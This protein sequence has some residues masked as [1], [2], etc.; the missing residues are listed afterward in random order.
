MSDV[1]I[2]ESPID[3]AFV[4]LNGIYPSSDDDLDL[5]GGFSL[6]K[7]N[8]FLL[9]A[10]S[11]YFMGKGEFKDAA[12]AHRYLIYR[13]S[14]S[15]SGQRPTRGAIVANLQNGLLAFQ[16]I[17]PVQ[18]LG[19]IFS[20]TDHGTPQFNLERIE[21]R[22]PTDAGEWAWMRHFEDGLLSYVPDMIRR[23]L[24][25]MADQ[26][27][28]RKNALSFLQ[29]GLE[30]RHPLIAGL[31]WVTGLEALLNSNGRYD[32][33]KKVS[34]CL[35]AD[36]F[37][38]PD[39]NS[40]VFSPPNTTVSDIA[41]DLFMLRNTLAH[42]LDLRKAASNEKTPVDLLKTVSLTTWSQPTQYCFFLSEAACYLLGAVLQKTL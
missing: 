9:S 3:M 7:P 20:G 6:V 30:H 14:R 19:L 8:D 25:V 13:H 17:K 34:A 42:G 38:F 35:G 39:W 32:F 40:P 29:L 15:E 21:R 27:A 33:K 28:E 11:E 26:S 37:A 5:G 31:L 4:G 2:M 24:A 16:I 36:T 22:G 1:D 10:R 18:S 23:V 41:L 12:T